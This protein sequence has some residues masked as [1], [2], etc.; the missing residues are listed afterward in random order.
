M[1]VV[2]AAV[3]LAVILL[4]LT[5][6]PTRASAA[7]DAESMVIDQI[8]AD[9]IAAGLV[10][11]RRLH[12]LAVVAGDRA[13]AMA[14]NNVAN[15]TIGGDIGNALDRED[16]TWY[17]Y[18]EAVGYT[19]AGW[20]ADAGSTLEDA[21]MA[22]PAHRALLMSPTYNYVGVGLAL[23][24]SNGR[25]FGSVVLTESADENGARS[26][27]VSAKTSGHDIT[28]S[29]S[30]ADLRLQTHTAGLR[31]Y[32]VQYRVESGAWVTTRND[33]TSTSLT[34]RDRTSGITYGLRIRATDRHG[35]IG[36]WSV[37]SRVTLP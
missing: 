4:P 1:P 5:S 35:N 31:D 2:S 12:G 13:A 27:F 15:H 17:S 23:R 25:T 28:W 10:P 14:A 9:R 29:W 32:D 7:T 21:W 36:A 6:V 24:S 37:E 11:L 3:L 8:N 34:L 16:V 30:G 26:W 33:S 22:S 19:T 20:A 18:G